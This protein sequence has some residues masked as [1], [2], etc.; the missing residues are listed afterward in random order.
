MSTTRGVIYIHSAPSALRP[1][2]EWAISGVLGAP[3]N[4]RWTNQPA[5]PGTLRA[6]CLWTGAPGTNAALVAAIKTCQRVRFEVTMD[7]QHGIEGQRV[8]YTPTLGTFSASTNSA[9]DIVVNENRLRAAMRAA[10]LGVCPVDVTLDELLGTAWDAELE[11]FR[12]A[13]ADTPVR[14]LHAAV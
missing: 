5:A 4:L 6:E 2:I 1:H 14:W 13:G 11:T 8:A 12:H 9:G 7:A 3:V 10:Q